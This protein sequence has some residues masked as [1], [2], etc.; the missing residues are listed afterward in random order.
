MALLQWSEDLSVGIAE[1]DRQHQRL[2]GL[3]NRLYEAMATG[4]GDHIK[5]E[6]LTELLTCAKV[7]LTAEERLMH[8]CGYPQLADHKRLHDQLE[9]KVIQLN[10]KTLQGRMASSGSIGTVLKDWLVQHIMQQDKKYGQFV[11]A[12]VR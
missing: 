2:V 9:E 5:K 6:I 10:E 8:A 11:C 7:H 1:M 3:V 4:Q 12:A